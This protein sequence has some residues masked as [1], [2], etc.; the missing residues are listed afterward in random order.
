M[1]FYNY[2]FKTGDY[3]IF[4]QGYTSYCGIIDKVIPI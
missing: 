3:V 4:N 1:R 2:I